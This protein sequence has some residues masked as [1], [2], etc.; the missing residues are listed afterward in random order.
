MGS[1]EA[2]NL[3][4]VPEV[5]RLASPAVGLPAGLWVA[6]PLVVLQE[7]HGVAFL[8][9]LQEGLV[10]AFLVACQADH[11]VACQ[12]ERQEDHVEASP[13]GPLGVL[14]KAY[15]AVLRPVVPFREAPFPVPYQEVSL[16]RAFLVGLLQAGH[17]GNLVTVHLVD[18]DLVAWRQEEHLV[19]GLVLEVRLVVDLALEVRR[20]VVLQVEP[21]VEVPDLEGPLEADHDLVGL[22]EGL[23]EVVHALVGPHMVLLAMVHVLVALPE[24]D[25]AL[26][27]HQVVLLVV[28]RVRAGLLCIRTI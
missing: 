6:P 25:R 2:G 24:V 14:E 18:R 9:V 22:L 20:L 5:E 7:D 28:D 15:Q 8:V 11:G 13:V 23:Q 10:G 16:W 4:V 17:H 21:Q 12:A 26:V 27:V 19:E 3:E 1:V